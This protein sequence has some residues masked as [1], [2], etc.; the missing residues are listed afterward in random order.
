VALP[1]CLLEQ[2]QCGGG[3]TRAAAA[4]DHHFGERYLRLA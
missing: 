2:F 1:G 3:I 4:V